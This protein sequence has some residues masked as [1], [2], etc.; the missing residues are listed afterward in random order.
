MQTVKLTCSS[1]SVTLFVAVLTTIL[2]AGMTR[3]VVSQTMARSANAPELQFQNRLAQGTLG[4]AYA[5][6]L[7]NLLRVNTVPDTKDNHNKA[8][9]MTAPAVFIKAGGGY[10]E[11]WTRDASLNSW[12]AASLLEPVVARNTLW[13]VCQKQA[14]GS[15]VLQRDN[16][17]WDKVI[18][19]PAAWNHFKVT[20]DED[21]LKT[22]YGVAQDELKLTRAEHFNDAYGLFRGPAFFADG[23]AAYPEPEYDPKNN[24]SFVLDHHYTKDMMTLSTNCVYYGAYRSAA[25]MAQQLERPMR[26][27]QG[28]N[29]AAGALQTAI[30]R[31]LWISQKSTYGYF[32][33]GA[34]PLT[35]KRD[36]TQESIGLAYAILFGVAD[37]KQAQSILETAHRTDYGVPAQWPHF[38][39]Y[40][41]AKPGRHNVIIWP[42]VNGMWACAAAKSGD[43]ATFRDETE[44]L[45]LLARDNGNSF[46]EIYNP[47]SG[48]PDGG[49]QS[50]WH[51]PSQPDQTWSA[52]AYLRMI[53]QGLFGMDFQS[54]GLRFTPNLPAEWGAVKLQGI[55]YR[56][57][58]LDVSLQGQGT[59]ITRVIVD[60]QASEKAFIPATWTGRHSVA[61]AMKE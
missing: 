37:H 18:W 55:H 2:F 29:Q 23:I 3:P 7:D 21:F 41:D 25:Q 5:G 19:I 54:N 45:A 56:G 15:I 17:W 8:G 42:V 16:Q 32:I 53:Y 43:L 60:G 1:S 10:D 61:I 38:P 59:R 33:H 58:I 11:P 9:M 4:K 49:W 47:L 6:A 48:K 34:G 50:G 51:W 24:S 27:I 57:I 36:D 22:A 46:Y 12:N 13:A 40:S 52:T 31:H 35:G 28:W 30:N 44:N 14:D 20:G 26:E 39:R